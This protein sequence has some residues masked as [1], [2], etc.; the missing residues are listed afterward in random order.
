M[1]IE[2]Q[3]SKLPLRYSNIKE[4]VLVNN[5]ALP[6]PEVKLMGMY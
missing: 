1:I 2:R 5:W 4:G 6:K 3:A